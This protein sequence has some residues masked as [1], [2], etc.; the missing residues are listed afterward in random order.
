MKQ[1]VSFW[2]KFAIC[3]ILS[4]SLFWPF[5]SPEL[6]I[7]TKYNR[8]VL[9]S[10]EKDNLLCKVNIHRIIWGSRRYTMNCGSNNINYFNFFQQLISYC[11]V[12]TV[13]CIVCN[14]ICITC[15]VGYMVHLLLTVVW[16]YT[17][18]CFM[19]WKQ[20]SKVAKLK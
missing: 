6:D 8:W 14:A 16:K 3:F 18:I 17:Y 20:W 11:L 19:H 12:T 1:E 9:I 10:E 7:L 13:V 2:I 15:I 4:P 5:W